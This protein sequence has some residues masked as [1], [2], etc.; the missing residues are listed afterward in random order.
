MGFMS[1]F[2]TSVKVAAAHP[3]P[4]PN[5]EKFPDALPGT[6]APPHSRGNSISPAASSRATQEE[7]LVDEIKHQVVLNHLYQHQCSSLW[8]RDVSQQI[9]GVMVRKKRNDYL[10][11]PPGLAESAFA[12]AM[13]ML[14]VQVSF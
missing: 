5:N 8:I 1:Y 13:M 4:T 7:R 6:L 12:Q 3:P 11:K 9:E 10:F 14:N 2:K